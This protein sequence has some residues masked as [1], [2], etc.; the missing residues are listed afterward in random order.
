[1]GRSV[2]G[3]DFDDI[4]YPFNATYVKY[5]NR[6]HG[7]SLTYEDIT[8]YDLGLIYGCHADIV[9][10]RTSA[11]YAS[12]DHD[13]APPIVGSVEALTHLSKHY[14]LHIVT[15]RREELRALTEAW[16]NR[17]MPGVFVGVHFTNGFC[18]QNG[19]KRPKSEVCKELGARFLI[20]D[21]LSHA[22]EVAS[23]GIPVFM[24]DRPWNRS[25]TPP[26]VL[27]VHAWDEITRTIMVHA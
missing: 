10:E 8:C 18:A 11:F 4:S 3:V 2:I 13:E 12:L 16:I 15:S 26:S 23:A 25:H 6:E 9:D 14:D 22:E 5:H 19:K 17:F 24:P 21:A 20:D 7:S 27:R 1:M